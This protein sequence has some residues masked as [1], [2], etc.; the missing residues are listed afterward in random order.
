MGEVINS[1]YPMYVLAERE[2]LGN[3]ANIAGA[4]TI[5]EKRKKSEETCV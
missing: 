5:Y 4:M 3:D 2:H 1:L